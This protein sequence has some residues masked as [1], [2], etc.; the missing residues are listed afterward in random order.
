MSRQVLPSTVPGPTKVNLWFNHIKKVTWN[1]LPDFVPCFY[2]LW[3]CSVDEAINLSWSVHWN[4]HS[5]L[6]SSPFIMYVLNL[7]DFS[8]QIYEKLKLCKIHCFNTIRYCSILECQLKSQ[9]RSLILSLDKDKLWCLKIINI[10]FHH[11]MSK[12]TKKQ[13][14]RWWNVGLKWCSLSKWWDIESRL[15]FSRQMFRA[16]NTVN[17]KDGA[18]YSFVWYR[19]HGLCKL[20]YL[21]P[22]GNG[23]HKYTTLWRRIGLETQEAKK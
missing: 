18:L 2:I 4:I 6:Q 3:C 13:V 7:S 10:M 21:E 19:C 16:F 9:L 17:G 15:H 12:D 8:Y 23:L 1:W 5:M 22:K 20:H 14:N 11:P